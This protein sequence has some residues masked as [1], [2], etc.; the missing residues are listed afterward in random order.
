[1]KILLAEKHAALAQQIDDVA[2]GVEHV[3]AD[4]FR[5]TGFIGKA[6]MVIDWR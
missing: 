6:S 4:E 1:M 3:F 2:V 5:Q